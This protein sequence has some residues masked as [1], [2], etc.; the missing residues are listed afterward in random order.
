MQ[1][2]RENPFNCL[3]I[4]KFSADAHGEISIM[5]NQKLELFW[6]VKKDDDSIAIYNGNLTKQDL[7]PLLMDENVIKIWTIKDERKRPKS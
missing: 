6:G 2:N 3:N 4:Q 1:Y 5:D 7:V